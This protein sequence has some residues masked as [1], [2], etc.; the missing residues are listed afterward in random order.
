[1]EQGAKKS[2][3]ERHVRTM[4]EKVPSPASWPSAFVVLTLPALPD[5]QA[6]SSAAP[7][8]GL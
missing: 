8:T 3:R 6:E 4:K 1:M 2:G 5:S 7:A